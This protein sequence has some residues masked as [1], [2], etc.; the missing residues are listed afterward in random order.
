MAKRSFD[1]FGIMPTPIN[2]QAL[3]GKSAES[4]N[5]PRLYSLA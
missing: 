4:A 3:G 1:I 2:T 5:F